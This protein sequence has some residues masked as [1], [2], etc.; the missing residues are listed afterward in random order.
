[1]GRVPLLF[2][3]RLEIS[4][5]GVMMSSSSEIASS[6]PNIQ[7]YRVR[8][9]VMIT[10]ESFGEGVMNPIVQER[11]KQAREDWRTTDAMT[12]RSYSYSLNTLR[13]TFDSATLEI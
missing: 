6:H 13:I 2:S 10:F 8:K 1:M 4:F 5:R 3:N 11:M 12:V 7:Q 9:P